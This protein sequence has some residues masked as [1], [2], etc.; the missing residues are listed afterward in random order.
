MARP[1]KDESEKQNTVLPPIRCT[2]EE[3]QQIQTYAQ[4]AEMSVSQYIRTMALQGKIIIKQSLVEFTYLEQLNK[5]GV[6]LNQQTKKFNATGQPPEQLMSLWIQLEALIDK[7][8]HPNTK[9]N[10]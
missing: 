7:L 2:L 8:M 4:Q 6:N 5:I 3:K 9:E 10:N 1:K